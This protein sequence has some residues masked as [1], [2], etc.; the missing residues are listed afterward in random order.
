MGKKA[1]I[2]PQKC[3]L[4][5]V[6]LRLSRILT[7]NLKNPRLPLAH[8]PTEEPA[9]RPAR[10]HKDADVPVRGESLQDS[11]LGAIKD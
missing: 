3:P 11:P 7:N 6:Q 8:L 2:S 5:K 1:T 9:T 4:K 10:A